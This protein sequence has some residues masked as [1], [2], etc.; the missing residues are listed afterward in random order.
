MA[1]VY[2]MNSE[3]NVAQSAYMAGDMLGEHWRVTE[4]LPVLARC[5]QEGRRAVGREWAV[6]GLAA[7]S[8]RTKSRRSLDRITA[9]LSQVT[10]ADASEK[11]RSRARNAVKEIRKVVKK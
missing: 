6:Y 3:R 4:A 10:I 7:L 5:A 2:L 9:A 8:T 11:V 1:E